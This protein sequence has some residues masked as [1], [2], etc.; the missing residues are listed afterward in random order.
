MKV[1]T[2]KDAKLNS[3]SI[4]DFVFASVDSTVVFK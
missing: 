4:P 3:R 1:Y 2:P